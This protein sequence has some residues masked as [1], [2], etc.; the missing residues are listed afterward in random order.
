MRIEELYFEWQDDMA[1]TKRLFL[2]RSNRIICPVYREGEMAH[3]ISWEDIQEITG[4]FDQRISERLAS[5]EG[6]PELAAYM[7]S[8]QF[9]PAANLFVE[10]L[11]DQ[12]KRDLTGYKQEAG[13]DIEGY[14]IVEKVSFPTFCFEVFP[15]LE[16]GKMVERYGSRAAHIVPLHFRSTDQNPGLPQP[17]LSLILGKPHPGFDPK[18]RLE[19]WQ[20]CKSQ[21]WELSE[22]AMRCA[23]FSY[24]AASALHDADPGGVEYDPIEVWS[25]NEPGQA[26]LKIPE[27][28]GPT[29]NPI[30]F[31]GGDEA[32]E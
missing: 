13:F 30:F 10:C 18:Q 7:R 6:G 28:L 26:I 23:F 16:E 24:M 19:A 2:A 4:S 20:E 9:T 15:R 29:S 17:L 8:P 31:F 12:F 25:E 21:F 27:I 11:D 22:Q 3:R 1:L 5:L 32:R 14:L